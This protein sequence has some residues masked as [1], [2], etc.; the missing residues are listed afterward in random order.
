MGKC[1]ISANTCGLGNR[2]KCLI[3]S[4][5]IAQRYSLKLKLFW[6]KNDHCHCDFEDLFQDK[7][8]QIDEKA[9]Q[10]LSG[11]PLY[12][13]IKESESRFTCPQQKTIINSSWRLLLFP[14]EI[15][16]TKFVWPW[17]L[18][19]YDGKGIDFKYNSIPISLRQDILSFIHRLAPQPNILKEVEG[20]AQDFDKDTVS[21]HVR[22]WQDPHLNIG[23]CSLFD[24]QNV[25][26]VLDKEAKGRFFV[27]CD[28]KEVME[29]IVNR[30]GKRVL[31]NPLD[32][33]E[34]SR[35]SVEGMK[36]S[37]I[38][39]L[40]LTR[41]KKLITSYLTTYSELAWW[42]GGCT[43]HVIQIPVPFMRNIIFAYHAKKGRLPFKDGYRAGNPHVN[44]NNQKCE[45]EYLR[46]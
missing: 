39:L 4:M 16:P 18:P 11:S 13:K 12:G 30:Y 36:V 3:S 15:C 24:I 43:E 26:K 35:S 45:F 46:S 17:P 21:I 37:L 10:E 5:R 8:E 44:I 1:I 6:P 41:S 33:F 23:R 27:A 29:E 31:L 38:N 42:W 7:I 28:F 19:I 25:F 34:H 2:I 20:V 22:T 14:G 9:F 32:T 40:L